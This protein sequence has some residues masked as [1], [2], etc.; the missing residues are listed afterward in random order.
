[1]LKSHKL[2]IVLGCFE[3]WE[4]LLFALIIKY[5]IYITVII[6]SLPFMI[7]IFTQGSIKLDALFEL[8]SKV[9]IYLERKRN[10]VPGSITA[11]S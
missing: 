2:Y 9:A 3:S 7:I 11:S 1:M 4:V 8:Y 10:L 5:A 6:N